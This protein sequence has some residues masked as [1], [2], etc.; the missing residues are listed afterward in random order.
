VDLADLKR[1]LELVKE[2]PML[3]APS[4]DRRPTGRDFGTQTM[5]RSGIAIRSAINE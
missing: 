4:Y 1:L 2:N 5:R 3:A